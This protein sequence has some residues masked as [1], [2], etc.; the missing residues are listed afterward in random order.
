MDDEH[1]LLSVRE[2]KVPGNYSCL[3]FSV[4][5]LTLVLIVAASAIVGRSRVYS[6]QQIHEVYIIAIV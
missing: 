4:V 1:Q 2:S 6:H 5:V 3:R